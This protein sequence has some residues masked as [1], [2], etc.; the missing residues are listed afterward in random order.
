M[1]KIPNYDSELTVTSRIEKWILTG[2]LYTSIF[3]G[4][5]G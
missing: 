1:I 4:A 2:G 5:L 3:W